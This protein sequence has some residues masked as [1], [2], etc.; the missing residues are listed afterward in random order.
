MSTQYGLFDGQLHRP[1][2]DT[3]SN[4]VNRTMRLY[5]QAFFQMPLE[6]YKRFIYAKVLIGLPETDRM[7]QMAADY[8]EDRLHIF[9]TF[10]RDT[11]KTPAFETVARRLR[12]QGEQ[13]KNN[14]IL[15]P[16]SENRKDELSYDDYAI[17]F[18][19]D[20]DDYRSDIE[21]RFSSAL[22]NEF[23]GLQ[24]R[25]NEKIKIDKGVFYGR[26]FMPDFVCQDLM[27]TLE[28]DSKLHHL[29]PDNFV[30]DRVKARALQTMGY[31]HL[32]FA[33]P[34]LARQGG[35]KLAMQEIA[36]CVDAQLYNRRLSRPPGRIGGQVKGAMT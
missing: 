10:L 36:S 1:A 34:E 8:P 4:I 9:E 22:D 19:H 6:E 28:I 13:L 20:T 17:R 7:L 23:P 27:I 26:V 21:A 16:Q 14:G 11:S 3:W 5:T 25:P 24:W 2:S 32:Q 18:K 31:V 30:S 12:D 33:G 15:S 29:N 35:I